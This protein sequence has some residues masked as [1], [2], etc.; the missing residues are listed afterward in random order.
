MGE[1]PIRTEI[2]FVKGLDRVTP[3][4]D[5]A[6]SADLTH[7]FAVVQETFRPDCDGMYF[8]QELWRSLVDFA[9]RF[10]PDA[11]TSVIGE[12]EKDETSLEAFMAEWDES[13]DPYPPPFI[14]VR[15]QRDISL[16][17]ATE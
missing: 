15:D 14:I 13:T 3:V 16:L 10:D 7:R 6:E 4:P 17:I 5:A 11:R 12:G 8:D 2:S 1:R 9:R